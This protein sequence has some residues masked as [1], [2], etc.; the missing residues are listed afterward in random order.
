MN[1]TRAQI[2]VSGRCQRK[3]VRY[4][5]PLAIEKERERERERE[6]QK[7]HEKRQEKI[8]GCRYTRNQ[9]TKNQISM[10]YLLENL[11][12]KLERHRYM[13]IDTVIN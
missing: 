9:S 5:I 2:S 12:L 4:Q 7:K 1:G 11:N 6:V 3:H 10:F 13:I 8:E